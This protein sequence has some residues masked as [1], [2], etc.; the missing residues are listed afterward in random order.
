M[1][2]FHSTE[3]RLVLRVAEYW[4]YLRQDRPF[5]RVTDIDPVEMGDDWCD[6]FVI[7]PCE[8]ASEAVFLFAGPRLLENAQLPEDWSRSTERRIGDC[9][10]GSM[11]GRSVRYLG[12]VLRSRV[13]VNVG[14]AF[15]EGGQEVR[16]RGTLFPFSSNGR[17][18]DAVLGAANCARLED[19][20]T[21]QP[22]A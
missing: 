22:A 4:D 1:S 14:E 6:C 11:L 15:T 21:S 16:L 7:N 13:P 18:I 2:G 12:F 20:R 5:P 17:D 10:P 8:P 9:P 19:V 3:R